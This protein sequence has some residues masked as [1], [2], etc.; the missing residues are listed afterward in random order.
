MQAE[1]Q[2][3]LALRRI[4][5]QLANQIAFGSERLETAPIWFQGRS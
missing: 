3:Q 1:A 4:R 2:I 5:R